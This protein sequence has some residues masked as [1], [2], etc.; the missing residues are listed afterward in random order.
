MPRLFSFASWNVEH[1]VGN[2]TRFDRVATFLNS[3]GPP[4]A[5]NANGDSPPDI[6]AVQEVQSSTTVFNEFIT[7]MPTH[8][9]FIT[10]TARSP[11]DILV[12]VN[13]NF[14]AFYEQRTEIQAGMP[15]LRPG[16][17]RERR[18]LRTD[19]VLSRD[20]VGHGSCRP[21]AELR[22]PYTVCRG[23]RRR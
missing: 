14:T 13:R 22:S 17:R 16:A 23:Y 20:G 18:G 3:V 6:F 10:V 5:A 11:I 4:G 21:L 12:G 15:T 8:Q 2:Q 1:F 19:P 9:F 7:R